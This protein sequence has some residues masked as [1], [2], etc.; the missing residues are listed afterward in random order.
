V[1]SH[2]A[3][4]EQQYVVPE[5]EQTAATQPETVL[6]LSQPETSA[7]PVHV[8]SCAQVPGGLV[9]PPPHTFAVQVWPLAHVPQLRVP[10]QPSAMVPHVAP[11]AEHVCETQPPELEPEPLLDPAPEELEPE[12]DDGCAPEEPDPELD[13]PCDPEEPELDE[14]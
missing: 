13:A 8:R 2:V 9:M 6:P 10:P 3:V 12:L 5:Y 14:A 7:A 1:A 4:A 11:S